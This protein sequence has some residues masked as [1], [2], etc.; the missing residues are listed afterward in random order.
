[1][2]ITNKQRRETR[3]F[4]VNNGRKRMSEEKREVW[5]KEK[6]LALCDDA[7]FVWKEDLMSA[8]FPSSRGR[9]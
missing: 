4:D 2:F 9:V 1:M 7:S 3:K 8:Y 6:A 5:M